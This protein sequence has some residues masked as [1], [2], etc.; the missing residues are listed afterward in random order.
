MD[1][2]LFLVVVV[3][4]PLLFF[5]TFDNFAN[6]NGNGAI[7]GK[8]NP[9]IDCTMIGPDGEAGIA[10][11]SDQFVMKKN[12]DVKLTCKKDFGSNVNGKATHFDSSNVVEGISWRCDLPNNTF[13]FDWKQ[14]ISASGKATLTCHS[15]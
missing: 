15:D 11:D 6:A 10:A 9:S 1:K 12:G 4:I 8:T 5:F 13:T 7:V 3:S 14:T 2:R